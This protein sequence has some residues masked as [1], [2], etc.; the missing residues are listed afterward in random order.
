[1]IQR[2]IDEKRTA[3]ARTVVTGAATRLTS[4]RKVCGLGSQDADAEGRHLPDGV[5]DQTGDRRGDPDAAR[6]R[7]G[8]PDRSGVP[9]HPEFKDAKVRRRSSAVSFGWD[10]AFGT[11]F[12]VDRKEQLT[13]LLLIQ[14][15]VRHSIAISKMPSC[16]RLWIRRRPVASRRDELHRTRT[17]LASGATFGAIVFGVIIG[18]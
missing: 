10:G 1:L 5:D 4:K 18:L 12:W 9:V 11:H 3:G 17:N 7:Q 14:Q 8:S 6:G 13:G 2:Y 16:R 15:A